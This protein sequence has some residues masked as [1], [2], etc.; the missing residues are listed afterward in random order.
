MII[1]IRLDCSESIVMIGAKLREL[2]PGMII[3]TAPNRACCDGR[4]ATKLGE[5]TV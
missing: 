5:N 4:N 3:Q 2:L 1:T